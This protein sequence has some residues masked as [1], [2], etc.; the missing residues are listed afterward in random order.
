MEENKANQDI[1]T[2]VVVGKVNMGKTSV[3]ATLLEQDDNA[4]MRVS[5]TPGETTR[6]HEHALKQGDNELVRFIDTPGFSRAVDA[7]REILKFHGEHAGS[8]GKVAIQH[9]ITH[10]KGTGEFADEIIL[11]EPL[12]RGVGIIYVIDTSHPLR[13][14]YIAEMEIIR[15]TGCQRLA[16]INQQ[17]DTEHTADWKSKLGSYFNLVRSFNAHSATYRER[18]KLLRSLLEIDESHTKQIQQ[19]IRALES[20]WFSRREQATEYVLDFL[21]EA[22]QHEESVSMSRRD[23]ENETRRLKVVD[24]LKRSYFK[25]IANKQQTCTEAILRLYKHSL[26]ELED[27]DGVFE[28]VDLEAEETWSKWGLSRNQLTLAGGLTGVTAGGAVDLGTAGATHGLGALFGG[29][30]GATTTYFKGGSLPNFSISLEDLTG[31]PKS[32]DNEQRSLT[33]GVPDNENF[34]WILLDSVA[35][36]YKEVVQRSHGRRDVQRV[37]A[38]KPSESLVRALSSSE[39]SVISKWFSS[40]KKGKTDHSLEP[41][42]L[43]VMSHVLSGEDE[44]R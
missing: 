5:S 19:T 25:S 41:K 15:W 17:A 12:L 6:C 20:E 40:C 21:S 8:P 22:L 35:H 38:A 26:I 4:I 10:H 32:Q 39:R 37:T 14:S 42:V 24:D 36:Q 34:A 23:C 43:A 18:L 29:L 44:S 1:P 31:A 3:L 13:D 27:D 28:G 7:M 11:L 2:F 33:I 30:I 9:F 16:L